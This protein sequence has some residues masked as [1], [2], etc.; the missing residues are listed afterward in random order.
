VYLYH[1]DKQPKEATIFLLRISAYHDRLAGRAEDKDPEERQRYH[2]ASRKDAEEL[3]SIYE[4]RWPQETGVGK[5]ESAVAEAEK[6]ETI[7]ATA[8]WQKQRAG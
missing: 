5:S 3:L 7:R 6:L 1:I 4:K 8:L 2:E